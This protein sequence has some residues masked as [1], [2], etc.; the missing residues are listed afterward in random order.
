MFYDRNYK[1]GNLW[2][3]SSNFV[4]LQMF[5]IVTKTRSCKNENYKVQL[6][7]FVFETFSSKFDAF[8]PK[9]VVE[10]IEK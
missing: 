6:C 4:N 5:F 8:G 1:V 2:T 3:I 10:R 9:T 7:I